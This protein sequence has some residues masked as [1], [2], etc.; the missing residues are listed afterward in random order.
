[1]PQDVVEISDNDLKHDVEIL[2]VPPITLIDK[3][4]MW[5][6]SK[7]RKRFGIPLD[8]RIAYVQLG[9]GKINDINSE[10][11]YVISALLEKENMHIV[12]GESMLGDRLDVDLERVHVLRDYPNSIYLNG[13]DFSIQAGGYNSFHE[14]R[15]MAIPTLFLPNLNTGM[16]DQVTRCENA[17]S[18][19]WGL[20]NLNRSR[21]GIKQD[22]ASL[23]SMNSEGLYQYI[24]EN[25]ADV[26]SSHLLSPKSIDVLA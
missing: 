10:I 17:V 6:R 22:I 4:E 20:V 13:F 15:I 8:S 24:G 12:L 16:D 19:G 11:S 7:V 14:M 5:D 26:I 23:L 2:M 25:G 9:A 3:D 18:E 1:H 21:E